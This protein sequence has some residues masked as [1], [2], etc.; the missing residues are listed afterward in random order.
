MSP[1]ASRS[2]E[3]TAAKAA[4]RA[5][6]YRR[7]A[8]MMLPESAAAAA[9]ES[10]K[11]Q[12]LEALAPLTAL[13]AGQVISAFW[14]L[15]GEADLRPAIQVLAERGHPIALP[16]LQ[17]RGRPLRFHRYQPGDVLIPGQFNLLE[18][19]PAAA[20][21]QPDILLVPLVAFDKTGGR[22]GHGQGYYD[23]T[24]A[25]RRADDPTVP[26]IGIAF[27][28]QEVDALPFDAYDQR[29]DLVVTERRIHRFALPADRTATGGMTEDGRV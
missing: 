6:M 23:R 20:L 29:L 18:P 8:A 7:R 24:L 14:P 1:A 3:I 5:E 13:P 10:L 11:A 9:A 27:A 4:L 17:G 22:L 28:W 21:L 19:D 16:R 2:D 25:E 12:L 26:A 15:P